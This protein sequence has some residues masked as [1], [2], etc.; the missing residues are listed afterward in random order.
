[1]VEVD[2]IVAACAIV[3]GYCVGAGLVEVDAIVAVAAASVVSEQ[4]I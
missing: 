2:A 1:L 4:V 3:A